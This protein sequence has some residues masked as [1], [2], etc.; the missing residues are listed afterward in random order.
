MSME[1]FKEK[2]G[3]VIR[4]RWLVIV[5]GVWIQC[6]SGA[7]YTFGLYS[8][9]IKSN[10]HYNQSSL[11]TM[12]W[13]KDMGANIGILSGVVYGMSYPW[14]VLL[15][16]ALQNCVGYGMIWLSVTQRIHRPAL[17]QMCIFMF[18]AAQ[19]QTFFNTAVVVTTVNNFPTCRGTVIGLMKGFLGLSGAILIQIY[20]TMYEGDQSSYLLMLSWLPTL[21]SVLF[22]FVLH[23]YP[24][25]QEDGK[26][27]LDWF[28]AIAVILAVYL[29]VAIILENVLPMDTLSY[30]IICLVLLIFLLSPM[31]VAIKTELDYS[32]IMP[33]YTKPLILQENFPKEIP[34]QAEIGEQRL[35]VRV[36]G[37]DSGIA[38]ADSQRI[39]KTL[40]PIS[41]MYSEIPQIEDVE[42]CSNDFN[43]RSQVNS[44]KLERGQNFNLIQAMG[45]SDFWLLF[46]CM[47]CGMGSGLTTINN[48]SQIGASLGYTFTEISTLVSLWSIWNFLGR[49][50]AGYFSETF[51]HSKGFARPIFIAIA[52]FIM[53]SGHLVIAS[54]LPGSLYVGSVLIGICYGSQWSLMPAIT[55][56]IF[57][58][59]HFGTLFN[60]I[61]TAS[62]IGSY[63][64][65]VKVAGYLYDLEAEKEKHFE[66]VHRT[67]LI[68]LS[69]LTCHGSHC[70]RLS[71]FIM[72]AV[73]L[74]GCFIA[75]VLYLR[76]RKFYKQEIF[77]KI[78]FQSCHAEK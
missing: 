23:I 77:E 39:Q 4:S 71:F 69:E 72:S 10:L 30:L 78:H 44:G 59:Q 11:D 58:L 6:T 3:R 16:G 37:I 55:S 31:L 7:S 33:L 9:S 67:S 70:F 20:H 47:A 13:C 1:E 35:P 19:A 24:T 34:S 25:S 75:L 73:C 40:P 62:P 42:V 14:V 54:G 27:T 26:K 18:I 68:E 28:S 52:L 51:L 66:I 2:I 46:M 8:E 22:M 12:S 21:V 63:V 41:L 56:E 17:W 45:T 36:A 61:A 60:A 57:G 32:S 64:L 15:A 38:E 29:M 43:D 53:S 48:M 76:T 74:L 49:F 65:S 50:G 5:A